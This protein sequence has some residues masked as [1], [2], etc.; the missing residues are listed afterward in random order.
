MSTEYEDQTRTCTDCGGTF[1]WSA[2][3]Q[4]FF[5]EKGFSEPPKRC[6]DCRQAKREG[7][8]DFRQE[9]GGKR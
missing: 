6:K 3:E 8:G 7:R 9:K 4:A 1:M 2:G 5:H